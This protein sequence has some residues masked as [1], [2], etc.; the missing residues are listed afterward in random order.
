MPVFRTLTRISRPRANPPLPTA[1]AGP[2][3][4]AAGLIGRIRL[5]RAYRLLE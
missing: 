5:T 2:S 3:S 1:T 4:F